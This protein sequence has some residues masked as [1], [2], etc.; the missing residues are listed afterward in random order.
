MRVEIARLHDAVADD[1]DLRHPRPG[2]GDDAGRPHRHPQQRPHRAAGLAARPLRTPG[3]PLRRR[4]SGPA[5][6]ELHLDLRQARRVRAGA[7]DLRARTGM[8]WRWTGRTTIEPGASVDLGVRPDAIAVATPRRAMPFRRRSWWWSIS[9]ARRCCMCRSRGWRGW[10][11]WSCGG[12]R[13]MWRARWCGCGWSGGSAICLMGVGSGL[14]GDNER[15]AFLASSSRRWTSPHGPNTIRRTCI[16][17]HQQWP[18]NAPNAASPLS[19]SPTS[20]A[21]RASWRADQ[22]GTLAVLK[23]RRKTILEPVVREHQG[24][25]VKLMGDGV[26]MEFAS[27]VN[28]VKAALKLQE[29]MARANMPLSEDRQH[30]SCASASILAISSAR[31]RTSMATA[32]TSPRGWRHWRNR[33][34]S[35]SRPRCAT[36][37]R[38]GQSCLRGH[39]RGRAQEH[40]QSGA[41]VQG[42]RRCRAGGDRDPRCR[43]PTNL[44]LPCCRSPT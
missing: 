6:D 10:S 20:W 13:G 29:N 30:H 12:R 31:D 44:R 1:H 37:A 23:E 8:C 39:G 21:S 40:R 14:S 32:S 42:C 41:R 7:V 35:A 5:E 16:Q 22:A 15:P 9:A 34:A 25:I 36:N 18:M 28:A 19:R 2:R 11:R 33:A 43:F 17:R 3:Q 4:L 27:A 26:L 38:Q 24:R